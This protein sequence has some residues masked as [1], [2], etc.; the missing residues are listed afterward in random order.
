M[1]FNQGDTTDQDNQ[2]SMLK[3]Q[4]SEASI[5]VQDL[6]SLNQQLNHMSEQSIVSS[7]RVNE[8]KSMPKLKWQKFNRSKASQAVL[9]PMAHIGKPSEMSVQNQA[10]KR[11]QKHIDERDHGFNTNENPILGDRYAYKLNMLKDNIE[12][13]Q[14]GRLTYELTDDTSIVQ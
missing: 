9:D 3:N 13:A 5:Q 1:L 10:K 8:E 11:L 6:K 2:G 7:R 14:E 4:M 12:L